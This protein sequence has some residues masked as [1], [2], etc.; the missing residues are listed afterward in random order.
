L[1]VSTLVDDAPSSASTQD[2]APRNRRA[3]EAA[4]VAA[5]E[6]PGLP[7]EPHTAKGAASSSTQDLQQHGQAMD[8]AAAHAGEH[9]AAAAG[10]TG[11]STGPTTAG[12]VSTSS[13]SSGNSSPVSPGPS[14]A[15]TSPADSSMEAEVEQLSPAPALDLCAAAAGAWGQGDPAS[16]EAALSSSPAVAALLEEWCSE[17]GAAAAS[18][19]WRPFTAPLGEVAGFTGKQAADLATAGFTNLLQVGQAGE[20]GMGGRKGTGNGPCSSGYVWCCP[21]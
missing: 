1:D 5:P 7:E 9:S 16:A 13:S 3:R 10:S 2:A 19:A 6:Q 17:A 12:P 21:W 8:T 18:V 20:Q 14:P 4:G 15:A 11:S